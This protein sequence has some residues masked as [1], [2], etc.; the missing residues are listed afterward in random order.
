MSEA[1]RQDKVSAAWIN[2]KMAHPDRWTK[3]FGDQPTAASILE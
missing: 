3:A 2:K 1:A